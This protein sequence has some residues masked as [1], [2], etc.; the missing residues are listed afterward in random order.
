MRKV[1]LF[2]ALFMLASGLALFAEQSADGNAL[3]HKG[4][5]LFQDGDYSGALSEFQDITGNPSYADLQGD[6]SYWSSLALIALGRLD[7]ADKVLEHFLL[8]YPNNKN[9]PEAAYQ[10]GRLL[11]LQGE[12]DKAIQVLYT[13]IE[14]Y[15]TNP[16]VAN[17]YYWIGDSLYS[18]GHF[19]EAKRVFLTIL[20]NYPTSYKVEAARYKVSLINLRGR[21]IELL[22]LL[23]W[24]H[25]EALRAQHAYQTR[26][27]AYQQAL[28]AY[29]RRLAALARSQS[30]SSAQPSGAAEATSQEQG[31]ADLNRQIAQLQQE[32]K[33]LID[34]LQSPSKP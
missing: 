12:Y 15:K 16:F 30:A 13:F 14:A 11:Y 29:Q 18:T 19:G 3:L 1:L 7:E 2:S 21:E 6:A 34:R 26:E 28:I 9:I 4:Q 25:E 22:R 24:S 32:M 8:S 5:S 33:N 10:K 23:K 27:Q 17:A 31:I 20:Q